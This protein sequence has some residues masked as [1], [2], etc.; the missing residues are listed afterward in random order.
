MK[1]SEEE[2]FFKSDKTV[3]LLFWEQTYTGGVNFETDV[4]CIDSNH[5]ITKPNWKFCEVCNSTI[6]ERE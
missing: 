1:I 2:E 3:E 5:Y 6:K 4:Y